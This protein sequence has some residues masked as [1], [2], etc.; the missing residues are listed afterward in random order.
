MN[1]FQ[2]DALELR[3]NP[4]VALERKNP[5]EALNHV[6]GLFQRL[7]DRWQ[8]KEVADNDNL[9]AAERHPLILT[10]GGLT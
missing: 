7:H 6:H 9:L 8:L 1:R 4:K 5:A 2:A 3:G 10:P